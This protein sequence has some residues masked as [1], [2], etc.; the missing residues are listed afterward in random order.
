MK[1]QST[2]Y[3]DG[4]FNSLPFPVDLTDLLTLFSAFSKIF[5]SFIVLEL[6]VNNFWYLFC[7]FSQQMSV[8][9]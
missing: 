8:M 5:H 7:E 4:T 2:V 6:D 1:E 3:R 9:V